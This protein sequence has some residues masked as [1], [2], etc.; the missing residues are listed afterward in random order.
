MAT[1]ETAGTMFFLIY[2]A[3]PLPVFP[4]ILFSTS[5][6]PLIAG[7]KFSRKSELSCDFDLKY[8]L[9]QPQDRPVISIKISS[10]KLH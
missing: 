6:I 2:K 1:V 10:S 7:I 3:S 4:G 5:Q 8:H 9:P